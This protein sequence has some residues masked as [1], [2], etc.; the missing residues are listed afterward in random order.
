MPASLETTTSA[1]PAHPPSLPRAF[2]VA[3]GAAVLA[4]GAFAA[5]LGW[6]IGGEKSVRYVSDAGTVLA[7]LVASVACIRAGMRHEVRDRLFWWLLGAGCGAWM[8]GEVIWTAYDLA[9]TGGPP[10]PS[11]ADLG[12]LTFI[13]LAVGALLSHPGLR[14][15][16]VE[17]ARSLFDGLAIALALLFLSWVFV[18]GPLWRS[19]DLTTLGGVVTFA[20]PVG[21]VVIAFFVLLALR[22]M[23]TADRLELW[24]LLAGLIALAL[25]DS[26][27]A[28]VVE[29]RNY[30]SGNLLDTGWFAG[31]LGIALG[32]LASTARDIPVRA[33]S[34]LLALPSLVAPLL[35]MFVALSAAGI[36]I[37]LKHRLDGVEVAMVFALI[38]LALVRQ[39]LLV[40]D[41][42]RV[43]RGDGMI[44]RIARA[45]LGRAVSEED[46]D[47]SSRA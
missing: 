32:A 13:P 44:D 28:Y 30:A 17:K 42:V 10:I 35:P 23:G 39:G 45:A 41:F 33:D 15:S 38:L 40:L 43:G 21:D 6:Q 1:P 31:F 20:Y 5:W 4:T 47:T 7:S 3:F 12:Y 29:V 14:G 18:L 22:R 46:R 19:S 27:Y 26:A 24:C 34:P 36:I 8:L 25:A 9:G 37:N 11:W 16:G 2:L